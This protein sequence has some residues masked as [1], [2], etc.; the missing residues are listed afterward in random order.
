MSM[1]EDDWSQYI[2]SSSTDMIWYMQHK[3]LNLLKLTW[4]GAKALVMDLTY[5]LRLISG[6]REKKDTSY[7][8]YIQQKKKNGSNMPKER[9]ET[10]ETWWEPRKAKNV[11]H[12]HE[13]PTMNFMES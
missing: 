3:M 10:W 12:K 11:S 4:L 2:C 5:I 1:M 9:F 13:I 6:L 7:H 8:S